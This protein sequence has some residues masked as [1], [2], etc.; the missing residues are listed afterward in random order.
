MFNKADSP[1]LLSKSGPS[2]E[3]IRWIK[4]HPVTVW[5][6]L[7]FAGL[8]GSF[9]LRH[10]SEW[11][12]VYIRA[13]NH[14]RAGESIYQLN[15]GYVYPPFMAA[16]ALPFTFLPTLGERLAWYLVNVVCLI[17]LVRWA[18]QL[19]GG[20]RLQGEKTQDKQEFFIF[21]LGLACGLRYA[22]DC[23]SHQQTDL[24]IGALVLGGCSALF[25]SH[26]LLAATCFG[27]AA[28]SKCTALLWC[29]FL[30]W[31]GHWLAAG[32]LVCTAVGVNLL[33]NLFHAP[34]D[35]GWWVVEW[36]ERYIRPLAGSDHIPGT[37]YSEIVYNQSLSGAINRWFTTDWTWTT[38]AGFAVANSENPLNPLFLKGL[39]YGLE[40]VLLAA[41]LMAIDCRKDT[42]SF[43]NPSQRPRE[44]LAYSMVLIL[45]LL[46]SPMSSKPHFCTVLLPA[47]CLARLALTQ[48]NHKLGLLLGAAI[49][50]GTAGIK[51]L[52]GGEAAAAA[53][54]CG[55]VM[56][57]TLF[58]F[59]GCWGALMQG[60]SSSLKSSVFSFQG[61]E[62]GAV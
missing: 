44:G 20:G 4:A 57:S 7:F 13:A 18:W 16:L 46:F 1:F 3:G 19:A 54:W 26:P 58:L 51:G 2:A 31:R 49:A 15:E 43:F 34:P 36:F 5:A 59:A 17:L 35:G 29:G 28:G 45:M 53:L 39:V 60:K 47:F 52:W 8:S 9:L 50:F 42:S 62:S 55:N 41:V 32:W 40:L 30:V 22:M 10:E 27:I 33:P 12:D 48:P 25:N 38:D 23:F 61:R 11:D 37:W 21:F 14:L 24:F 6:I 56:W